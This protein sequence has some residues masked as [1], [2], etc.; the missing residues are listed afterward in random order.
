VDS[1]GELHSPIY[2]TDRF[3]NSRHKPFTHL[4]LGN[5]CRQGHNCKNRPR[6]GRMFIGLFRQGPNGLMDIYPARDQKGIMKHFIPPGTKGYNQT[7]CAARD[8]IA[9][10]M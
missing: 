1:R 2:D 4:L 8:Q 7:F 10:E 6:R 9:R 3:P 5:F